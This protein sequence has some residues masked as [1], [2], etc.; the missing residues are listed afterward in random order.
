MPEVL[1]LS[2]SASGIY[3]TNGTVD[4]E[5]ASGMESSLV[6]EAFIDYYHKNGYYRENVLI[7]LRGL[8]IAYLYICQTYFYFKRKYLY[9]Q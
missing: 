8:R 5:T 1:S 7:L 6:A 9:L 3:S 4:E 2:G